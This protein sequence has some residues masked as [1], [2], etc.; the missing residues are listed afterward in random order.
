[1]PFQ[2]NSMSFP[3]LIS[4]VKSSCLA[5]LE[6]TGIVVRYAQAWNDKLFIPKDF[7]TLT[8]TV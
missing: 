3:D 2:S 5:S 7:G 1:M 4:E 8:R 6:F